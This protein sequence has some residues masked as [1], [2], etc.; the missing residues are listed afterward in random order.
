[1]KLACCYGTR[2]E[3][4]KMAP[5]VLE[6]KKR[7]A[8][9]PV[10]ICSGQHEELLRGIGEDFGLKPD[11]E[12]DVR[13]KIGNTS[14]LSELAAG[15][16][17]QFSA[18]FRR[19]GPD[20]V[21]VQGDAA[22]A[23]FA[24]LAAFHRQLPIYY[25]EAGLR[26]YDLS[27]PFPEEGYRQMISRIACVMFCPTNID[28]DNLI[29]ER[30]PKDRIFVVGNTVVDALKGLSLRQQRQSLKDLKDKKIIVTIHR[31]ENWGEPMRRILA[32][33]KK[34]A[35]S[36][37][38]YEFVVSVHPNPTVKA[39]VENNLKNKQRF[40][41]IN[42]PTYKQFIELLARSFGVIT[43]SG[44]IQEESPSLGIPCL[45]VR[46]KTERLAGVENGW[47]LV[48]GIDE[49][50][51]I[52]GFE[53]L[54]NWKRPKGGNPYGDGKASARIADVIEKVWK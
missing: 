19:I 21:M 35:A 8:V 43:D 7:E 5:V 15:L 30:I 41:L 38:E 6:L 14:D 18:A 31:R 32:A 22:S 36:Y 11:I 49:K 24:A 48:A 27:Q 51:I 39:V 1:M 37:S 53:W 9:V 12:L 40:T 33:L 2:P 23:A 26:T 25:I 50:R 29:Q 16:M 3:F 42:P 46:E 20:A 10:L 28:R 44:G 54:V 13:K 17:A 34:I 52:S 45:V 4:I 47:S